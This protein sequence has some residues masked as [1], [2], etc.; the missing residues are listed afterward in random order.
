MAVL[1]H[2][3]SRTF[4]LAEDQDTAALVQAIQDAVDAKGTF[5]F[6]ATV[7]GSNLTVWV[8]TTVTETVVVDPD[9]VAIGWFSG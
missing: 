2:V 9:G 8:N 5:K 3:G 6:E 1:V 7:G 4:S